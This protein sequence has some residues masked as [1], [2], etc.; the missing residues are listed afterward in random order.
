MKKF[1]VLLCFLLLFLGCTNDGFESDIAASAQKQ[2]YCRIITV[3]DFTA[4]ADTT[5]FPK[6]ISTKLCE[7][8]G[9]ETVA[10]PPKF[11]SS[12][13]EVVI[14]SSSEEYISSSSEEDI[15]SS[16]FFIGISSSS[17]LFV[18]IS[19]SSLFVGVSSSSSLFIGISSSSSVFVE[20]SSSSV[21]DV[22]S[23]SSIEDIPSSSSSLPDPTLACP[24]FQNPYY[25]AVTQKESLKDLIPVDDR[26]SVSYALSNLSSTITLNDTKDSLRF[27]SASST[28]RNLNITVT[29]DCTPFQSPSPVSCPITVV[30]A[31]KFADKIETETC[32]QKISVGPGT[33][34]VE[35]NCIK[36]NGDPVKKIGC[37]NKPTDE[38]SQSDFKLPNDVFTLNDVKPA[39]VNGGWAVVD[40]TP[41]DI[42]NRKS[43]RVL[44][45]YTKGIRCVA[46]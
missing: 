13:E 17:S 10:C 7:E 40:I 24:D 2:D 23:S 31:S 45:D 21:I 12:S 27:A 16:S 5:C 6:K 41:S 33:T 39:T 37:D 36:S 14:S 20:I 9:G 44:M 19:S 46:Q 3:D 32:D 8:L 11:S 34:V 26:C 15:S 18:G 35:I 28:K 4:T 43:K 22:V 42:A 30:V 29:A 38:A 25:V 1:F